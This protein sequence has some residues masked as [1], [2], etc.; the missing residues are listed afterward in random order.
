[1]KTVKAF[2]AAMIMT[3]LIFSLA[4]CGSDEPERKNLEYENSVATFVSAYNKGDENTLLSCFSKGSRESFAD[5][6][7]SAIEGITESIKNT[8]GLSTG[9]D[10]SIN[11]K[12]E[13]TDDQSDA[14][15]KEYTAKY[16]TRIDIK[17]AYSLDV[18]FR[19]KGPASVYEC[20]KTI[21]TVKTEN[22]WIIWGDVITEFS[23]SK[24]DRT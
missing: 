13:L 1:M 7:D 15:Q 24:A 12:S 10:Y 21:I 16:G 4:A 23:F 18:V 3:L 20:S 9:L 5:T 6:G 19:L 14:L 2:L 22:G 17:K 11:S 8:G